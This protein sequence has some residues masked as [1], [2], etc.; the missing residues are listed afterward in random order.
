MT[1]ANSFHKNQ[2]HP[3]NKFSKELAEDFL[4]LLKNSLLDK[5]FKKQSAGELTAS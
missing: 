5:S 1:S 3:K 4:K 2:I